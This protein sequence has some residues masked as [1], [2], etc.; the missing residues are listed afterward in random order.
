M[1]ATYESAYRACPC[2]RIAFDLLID[3]VHH[4]GGGLRDGPECPG[5]RSPQPSA[6]PREAGAVARLTE[7]IRPTVFELAVA[8]LAGI[9]RQLRRNQPPRSCGDERSAYASLSACSSA[10]TWRF[11]KGRRRLGRLARAAASTT[12][13]RRAL[14][15]WRQA[16][17]FSPT[18]AK[19]QHCA[20]ARTPPTC[21]GSDLHRTMTRRTPRASTCHAYRRYRRGRGAVLERF[22]R[23]AIRTS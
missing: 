12:D 21:Q 14:A 18:H 11:V 6:T 20:P 4:F 1:V 13:G 17:A 16:R 3:E 15:A 10:P 5:R 2:S 19:R 7:L 9:P 23:G 22:R 8:D